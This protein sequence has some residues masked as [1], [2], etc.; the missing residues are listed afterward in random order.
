MN[1]GLEKRVVRVSSTEIEA[2]MYAAGD[3]VWRAC[4]AWLRA[5]GCRTD[6]EI[7]HEMMMKRRREMAARYSKNRRGQR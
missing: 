2:H 1:E 5:R 3:E 6:G 7:A 4:D